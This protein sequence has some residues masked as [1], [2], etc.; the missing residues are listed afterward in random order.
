[1]YLFLY[2]I[3]LFLFRAGVHIAALKNAKAKKWLAGRKGIFERLQQAISK[4]DKI[5][6]FHC[7][8]LGEFEQGRPVIEKIRS[9]YP[10]Y[11]I[12]ITFFS[13]SGYEVRK[14]YN[15]A[16]YIF[17]LPIDSPANAKKFLHIVQPSLVVFVKYEY[18]YHYFKNISEQKIPFLLISAVFRADQPF[19]KWYGALYKKMLA[20][21]THLFVQDNQSKELLQKIGYTSTISITGDTRFDRVVE[22]ADQFEPIPIIESFCNNSKVIIA[23][24][25]WPDDEKML[26]NLFQHI[27]DDSVKLIIAPHE[28]GKN[29]IDDIQKLF[30][31][32]I[33]YS[34]LTPHNPQL[35]THNAPLII[36]SIGIL[37]RLYKYAYITYIGGGFT[38]DGIHNSLEAAVYGKPVL[39]GPVYSKYREAVELIETEGAKSFS[40]ADDLKQIV[41]ILLNDQKEYDQ[42]CKAAEQYVHSNAGATIRILNYI[43]ENRLLTN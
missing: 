11:K 1:M 26:Q 5:I 31:A 22:I 3:S 13:P 41:Y 36:D 34:Q 15:G 42:K 39:F 33:L 28:I 9:I 4:D 14:N 2:N 29:H 23:G 17:Y 21:F 18:W 27:S 37:S 43:Q 6:W 20:C 7:A 35:T 40:T 24:S 12:L 16:D 19:F 38:R 25:T 8:S 10:H 32:S 30:P